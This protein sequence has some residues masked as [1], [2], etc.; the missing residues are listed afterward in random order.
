MELTIEMQAVSRRNK[1]A[2]AS[3]TSV[4]TGLCICMG[5]VSSVAQGSPAAKG[6]AQNTDK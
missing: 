3:E 5:A 2:T 6:A 1:W 4:A